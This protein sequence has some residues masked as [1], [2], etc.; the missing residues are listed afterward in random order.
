MG[1][2]VVTLP[3]LRLWRRRHDGADLFLV[4]RSGVAPLADPRRTVDH[5]GLGMA[6]LYLPDCPELPTVLR[7]LASSPCLLAY[8]VDPEGVLQANLHRLLPSRVL[9][10]DPRP[11]DGFAGH[12]TDH[13]MAPLVGPDLPLTSEDLEPRVHVEPEE[14][15]RAAAWLQSSG[16]SAPLVA[17]HPGSG[18]ARKNWPLDRFAALAD[19]LQERGLQPVW[20]LG[21][22]EEQ[23]RKEA[24]CRPCLPPGTARELAAFLAQ[25]DLFVGNDSGPGHLAAAVGT[26]TLSL[27]GPTDPALWRPR[28]RLGRVLQAP[29][30]CLAQLTMDVVVEAA[31]ACMEGEPGAGR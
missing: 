23:T 10:H 24:G 30:G 9:V 28:S 31:V 27:F 6:P 12:V 14:A 25:V 17:L 21:P 22:L 3:A 7:P 4:A 15:S 29:G 20:I 5:D 13:L 8:A 2:F 11:P 19:R 1:D 26:P 16:L 18:A